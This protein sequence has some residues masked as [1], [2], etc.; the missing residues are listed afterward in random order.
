MAGVGIMGFH[1]LG[2]GAKEGI[3]YRRKVQGYIDDIFVDDETGVR[4]KLQWAD[5]NGWLGPT[6]F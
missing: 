1:A 3:L 5:I 4:R 6:A 2:Q